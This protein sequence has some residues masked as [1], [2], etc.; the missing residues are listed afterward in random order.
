MH[1][2][3]PFQRGEA[4]GRDFEITQLAMHRRI[5]EQD[6]PRDRL[7]QRAVVFL[8][9]KLLDAFPAEIVLRLAMRR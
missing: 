8:V 5:G 2:L 1:M 7:E 3:V 9:G 4:A 6:L